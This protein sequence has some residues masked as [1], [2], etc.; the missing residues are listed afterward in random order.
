M[1]YSI[2]IKVHISVATLSLCLG[3]LNL[4]VDRRKI[5]HRYIGVTWLLLT[6]FTIFSSFVIREINDSQFSILHLFSL[7]TF[8]VLMIGV[9]M[10]KKKRYNI[11]GKMMMS[12]TGGTLFAGLF[13]ILTSERYWGALSNYFGQFF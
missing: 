2:F 11:H 6:L 7:W 13:S 4:L 12:V 3:I 1:L 9:Y 5:I 10:L 8:T